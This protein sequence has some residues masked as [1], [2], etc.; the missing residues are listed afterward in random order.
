MKLTQ[1]R[2]LGI[3]LREKQKKKK[4]EQESYLTKQ[5]I[6]E[7]STKNRSQFFF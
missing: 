4:Q 5:Y 7:I 1:N 2:G 3:F 6:N